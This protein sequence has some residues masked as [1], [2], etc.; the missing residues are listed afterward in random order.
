MKTH[1]LKIWPL[2][3]IAVINGKKLFEIR[4]MDRDYQVGDEILLQEF[5]YHESRLTGRECLVR[6]SYIYK[7]DDYMKDGY[8]VLA[9]RLITDDTENLI[10]SHKN[11]SHLI[12]VQQLTER[13]RMLQAQVESDR[14]FLLHLRTKLDKIIPMIKDYDEKQA[15]E[16]FCQV[17]YIRESDALQTTFNQNNKH[18]DL[19]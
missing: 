6:I 18:A 12:S 1:K 15:V 10:F 4:K 13:C 8:G 19:L 11:D 5:N 2:F 3:F 14:L 7:S 17:L 9:I 16:K